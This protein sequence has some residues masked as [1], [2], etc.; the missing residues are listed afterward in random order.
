M[1]IIL[2]GVRQ[3]LLA[4]VGSFLIVF[5][6]AC[7]SGGD[8]IDSSAHAE[9]TLFVY[10][11]G[12]DQTMTAVAQESLRSMTAA[13]AGTRLNLV[14]TTGA[15]SGE[16]DGVDWT[17]TQRWLLRDGKK[18]KLADLGEQDMTKPET[19]RDFLVWGIRNYPA[20]RYAVVLNDHGGAYQGFGFAGGTHMSL[21]DMVSAFDGTKIATG[22]SFDLIGF[23][24]CMMASVEVAAALQP[25][26]R[27]LAASED[28]EYGAWDY[29]EIIS[30]IE[31]NPD[32]DGLALGKLISDTYFASSEKN[33]DFTFSVTDLQ[34]MPPLLDAI[35]RLGSELKSGNY[36][37]LQMAKI[38]SGIQYFST[39]WVTRTDVVDLMQLSR[40]MSDGLKPALATTHQV[41][42]PLIEQAV[43]YKV[44]GTS[45]AETG[46][47]N[48][49]MPAGAIYES[50]ALKDYRS[51]KQWMG[52]YQDFIEQYA[53][54]LKVSLEVAIGLSDPIVD[55]DTVSS[56]V[57]FPE[58]WDN[59]RPMVSI[60]YFDE[61]NQPMYAM[62]QID[63]AS[64]VRGDGVNIDPSILAVKA[65]M[66]G[67]IYAI[68]SVPVSLIP[69]TAP[70]SEHAGR[71]VIPV[72]INPKNVEEDCS[73]NGFLLVSKNSKDQQLMVTGYTDNLAGA[74]GHVI[75]VEDFSA[76]F[77]SGWL[78]YVDSWRKDSRHEDYSWVCSRQQVIKEGQSQW[79]LEEITVPAKQYSLSLAVA[80]Y[81][82]RLHISKEIQI[83]TAATGVVQTQA[84]AAI[85]H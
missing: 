56:F 72:T 48:I 31:R 19:L 46:G 39:D 44:V 69:T 79:S 28:L 25:Y 10:M 3:H 16:V 54:A 40:G 45:R 57:T 17:H 9:R 62:R 41:I 21:T 60:S 76:I 52:A 82:N 59:A 80:D 78:M 5:L 58:L 23:D 81:A 74:A 33:P 29:K 53:E 26:G 70:N 14:V 4:V 8:E 50:D 83:S 63:A 2:R 67:K 38:R 15:G 42:S 1:K 49:F 85:S 35:D 22:A 12:A 65:K 32:L 66:S 30:G 34:A 7:G 6:S 68:G 51:T 75:S 43:V 47:V 84:V 64:P 13:T 36:T 37:S 18:T 73:A 77:G 24:A 20:K 11:V 55:N 71:Y 27:Y 61:K